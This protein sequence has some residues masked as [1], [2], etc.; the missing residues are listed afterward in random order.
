MKESLIELLRCPVSGS[1]LRLQVIKRVRHRFGEQEE[2]IILEGILF[3][4]ADWFYPITGGIPRLAVEAFIQYERLLRQHI[5]DYPARR[6]RLE[7]DYP[8]LLAYVK[9][10]NRR[11]R[12][13]FS[14]EWS[15][16]NYRQD[17]IW[18]S[19]REEMLKIFLAET[20]ESLESLPGKLVFDAG[21]GSGLLDQLIA[22]K[23]CTV[24]AMDLSDSIERAY[25]ENQHPQAFF[26]QGDLQF[27]PLARSRFDIVH[28][29]GV[30]HHTN[31]TELS[32]SCLESCTRPGGKCSI[33]LYH[34]RKSFL[35]RVFNQLRRITS[36]LPAGLQYV[37]LRWTVFPP[38]YIVRRLTGRKQ[39]QR[40]IMIGI[41]D[42]LTPEF[43]W[44][45]RPD[46]AASW[47]S[48]RGYSAVQV[49]T[50][51]VFG[52]NMTGTKQVQPE[53]FTSTPG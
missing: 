36:K 39:N 11:T 27:P 30:L 1:P 5:D 3:S 48:K 52:F 2:D 17:K 51:E 8:G 10:K 6:Q 28:S 40:E 43:R 23:G 21:C 7:R 44:E 34:P 45:H 15:L 19:T 9:K 32:F 31:N 25:R 38:I 16:L 35:H 13:S 46:E 49:T 18:D 14:K 53:A 47:F 42:W 37:L 20:S 50:T 29:S 12:K 26:I 33:W 4:S 41:L 22:G 24:V